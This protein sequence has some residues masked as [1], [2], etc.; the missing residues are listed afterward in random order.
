MW[1]KRTSCGRRSALHSRSRPA[2]GDRRSRVGG[3]WTRRRATGSRTRRRP[4][5]RRS[6]RV[7]SKQ[8]TRRPTTARTQDRRRETPHTATS[9]SIS[10]WT[11]SS[12]SS[13][14]ACL[15]EP[16]PRNGLKSHVNDAEKWEEK[17][18]ADD[19]YEDE[20]DCIIVLDDTASARS[21]YSGRIVG[22][23]DVDEWTTASPIMKFPLHWIQT[24]RGSANALWPLLIVAARV[25][26]CYFT[27]VGSQLYEWFRV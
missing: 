7:S 6:L 22:D 17:N 13:S 11:S 18:A 15:P 2:G 9:C 23:D 8:R 20:D 27:H 5:T 3:A 10:H 21:D 16:A 4:R 19:E 1:W 25:Y 12:S 24:Q 26:F 14:T